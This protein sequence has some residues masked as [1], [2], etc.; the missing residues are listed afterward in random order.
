[1]VGVNLFLW[2]CRLSVVACFSEELCEV[3]DLLPQ[4]KSSNSDFDGIN[5]VRIQ[6]VWTPH[7]HC[8]SPCKVR[9]NTMYIHTNF[10]G[11]TV[12]PF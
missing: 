2:A 8:A 7:T 11:I 1:M 10:H 4:G 9:S 3:F 12:F 5:S 6:T